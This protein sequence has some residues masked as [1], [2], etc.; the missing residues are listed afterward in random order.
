[1]RSAFS[2]RIEEKFTAHCKHLNNKVKLVKA[3]YPGLFILA[4]IQIKS[5]KTRQPGRKYLR[6]N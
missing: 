3:P 5:K 4:F 2:Q 1:M 6:S